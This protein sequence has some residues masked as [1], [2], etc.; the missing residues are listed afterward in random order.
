MLALTG[1]NREA[2]LVISAPLM[3]CKLLKPSVLLLRITRKRAVKICFGNS[4][5]QPMMKSRK[6]A[7]ESGEE[8]IV[9][10]FGF[11]PLAVGEHQLQMW[12]KEGEKRITPMFPLCLSV[13]KPSAE[14]KA[15]SVAGIY[16]IVEC[17]QSHP[18]G[19]P[20]V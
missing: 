8:G 12:A 7:F 18:I 16:M 1:G 3:L 13:Q 6:V 19:W 20:R 11:I 15:C 4:E 10:E 17:I 9:I 14:S 5:I 2:D